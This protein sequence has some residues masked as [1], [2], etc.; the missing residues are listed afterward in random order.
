MSLA[1]SQF[2][3]LEGLEPGEFG[4]TLDP[5]QSPDE[6]V[7]RFR[8]S[9]IRSQP[10]VRASQEKCGEVLQLGLIGLGKMGEAM[11]ERL[12]D[13]GS[14]LIVHNRSA[15][16]MD[17][18]GK[19]GA[20]PAATPAEVAQ[21]ASVIL[22]VLPK[23]EDVQSVFYGDEGL[24]ENAT[25]GTLLMDCSTVEPALSRSLASAAN[26][27]NLRFADVGVGGLPPDAR[28]GRLNFM[29]GATP[30]D[31][32]AVEA[33]L[34]PLAATCWHCGPPGSGMTTKLIN[35]L[36]ATV[37]HVADLE[38]VLL[39]ERAGL[40]VSVFLQV[41][42]TTLAQNRQLRDRVPAEL[43]DQEHIPGFKIDLAYKDAV[44]GQALAEDLGV[45]LVLLS[46]GSVVLR[47]ARDRGF[48]DLSV[49]AL[50][51]TLRE[52]LAA[53]EVTARDH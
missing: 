50:L 41:L 9:P 18:L 25:A 47:E 14:G 2:E 1:D 30:E 35:N 19:R 32:S 53:L 6:I 36:L 27:R 37:I 11:A 43:T 12:L 48:G 21:R 38:A 8:L 24:L 10:V 42:Q 26:E 16:P 44:A 39:A 52:R 34:R 51:R 15:G 3:A 31:A 22:T 29:Y 40:D 49:S 17:R 13:S 45:P 7:F 4:A 23:G 28:A 46:S 33:T 5:A 20:T